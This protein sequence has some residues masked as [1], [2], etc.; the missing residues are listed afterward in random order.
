MKFCSQCGKQLTEE[1]DICPYC[2]KNTGIHP[3][4]QVQ[5]VIETSKSVQPEASTSDNQPKYTSTTGAKGFISSDEHVVCGLKNGFAANILSGEGFQKEDAVVTNKRLYYNN[6]RG[7][8]SIIRNEAIIDLRD[9]TGTKIMDYKFYGF[10]ILAALLVIAGFALW[11]GFGWNASSLLYFII[12]AIILVILYFIL[13]ISFLVIDYAG[14][15]IKFSVKKYS[16]KNIREF[17]RSIYSSKEKL[18]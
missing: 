14:G 16:I 4:Q 7:L 13:H 15:S 1:V 3:E 8:I 5:P 6:K 10:L 12:P 18:N 11:L 9:V 2:G 17:Q